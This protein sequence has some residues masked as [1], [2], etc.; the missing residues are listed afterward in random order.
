[1]QLIFDVS[2]ASFLVSKEILLPFPRLLFPCQDVVKSD[3]TVFPF[4]RRLLVHTDLLDCDRCSSLTR[5]SA[6]FWGVGPPK[7]TFIMNSVFVSH[8][9]VGP[10]IGRD[11]PPADLRTGR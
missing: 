7:K 2:H 9:L 4:G 6:T 1:M 11:V 8:S 5:R 3:L 10:V